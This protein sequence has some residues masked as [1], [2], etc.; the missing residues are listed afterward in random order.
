MGYLPGAG[1]TVCSA[2][3]PEENEAALLECTF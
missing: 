2:G 3:K 1:I